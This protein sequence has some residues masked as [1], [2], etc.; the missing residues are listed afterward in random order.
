MKDVG[1]IEE[2]RYKVWRESHPRLKEMKVV[3]DLDPESMT[4]ELEGPIGSNVRGAL[5][6]LFEGQYPVSA[7]L[8]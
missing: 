8:G 5:S 1:S 4:V 6:S 7:R 2:N 3:I